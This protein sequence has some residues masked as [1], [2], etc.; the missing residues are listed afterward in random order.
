MFVVAHYQIAD[1]D[2]FRARTEGPIRDRP[3]HWR[4]VTFAPARDGRTCYALWWA[5]SAEALTRLLRGALGGHGS[6]ECHEV[7]EEGALGLAETPV[8]VIRVPR[9]DP[10][11]PNAR[12]FSRHSKS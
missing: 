7:D 4:L 3:A 10:P 2:G 12:L 8:T 1:P 9:P 5:D 11:V 6:V